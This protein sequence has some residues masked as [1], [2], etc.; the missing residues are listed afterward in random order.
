MDSWEPLSTADLIYFSPLL[1]FEVSFT[2]G[3][4]T[5]IMLVNDTSKVHLPQPPPSQIGPNQRTMGVPQYCRIQ[6]FKNLDEIQMKGFL[7]PEAF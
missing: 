7:V 2:S 3:M 6:I 5:E 1:A 4:A